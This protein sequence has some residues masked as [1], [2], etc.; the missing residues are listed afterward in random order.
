MEMI[1]QRLRPD[2]PCNTVRPGLPALVG[3]DM[4]DEKAG[5]SD[6]VFDGSEMLA[7]LR[8]QEFVFEIL[9]LMNRE[10]HP[11]VEKADPMPEKCKRLG[12]EV[13]V[14][15]RGVIAHSGLFDGRRQR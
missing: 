3:V 15:E 8:I 12:R 11:T 5:N 1:D 9:T 13:E 7:K 10:G 4:G 2:E 6:P 14:T